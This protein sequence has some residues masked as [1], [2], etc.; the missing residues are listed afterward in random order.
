MRKPILL[1]LFSILLQGALMAQ[2]S[3]SGRITGKDG[4]PLIG[5]TVAVKGAAKGAATD[6]D[7]H[8]QLQ[9][10]SAESVLQFAYTGYQSKEI[11][12]GNQSN[13]D[14]L[15]EETASLINEVVVV[16]Y[17]AQKRSN[18]SGAVSTITAEE[19]S[20]LPILRTEQALQ[21][22]T[23]GVQVTQN[24]GS[25]GS[26]LTVRV[27]G[28]GTINNSDPLYI[29]DG[30]PV[31]GLDFLNPNDIESINVLK[32]AA[33]SAIYGARGAN[34]VVLITTRNG[35]KNQEGKIRYEAYFGMQSTWKKTNLLSAEEYAIL[36]NEAHIAAGVKPLPEFSNPAALGKGTNWLDAIFATAPM[37]SHQ[38]SLTGGSDKSTYSISGNYFNQ[39]GIVG[40][41]KAAFQRYT[42]RLNGTHEVK[43]WLNIGTNVGLT[44]LTRNGLPENNEFTTPLVRALNMDPVTP[45]RKADGTYAYSRYSDT[46]ITNPVNAIEQTHDR[47]R[48]NRLVG[49][50]YGELKLAPGLTYRSTYSVDA[51]FATQDIFY[52][53]FDLSNNTTLS[54]APAGEKRLINSVVKNNNTWRNW[55]WEN[56]LSWQ[57]TFAEAHVFNFTAGTT[58]LYNYHEYSGG[59]NT[60]LPSNNPKDAYI[61]NT[62]DPIASQSAYGGADE[63]ALNSYFG[64]VNYAYDDRYI[65]SGAFRMDGSSRFGANN[66]FGYFPSVSAGWILSHEAFWNPDLIN[67]FKLRASWGQN[68]NDKIG[69][70]SFTTIVNSGQNYTFGPTQTITNGSVSLRA[71]NPDLKWETITQTDFGVDLELFKGR[72]NFTGDYYIK[73]TSD[74]LY[75]APVP[76]TAGTEP[77]VRNVASVRNKGLELALNYRNRDHD[78]KYSVGGNISFVKNEVTSLG[79]GGEPVFAGRVQSANA[80]VSKTTIGQPIGAFFGYVTDG[81]FQTRD[82]VNKGA[83]QNEATAPGDI[84]F[85]D[86]NGDKVINEKDQTWIGN[87]APK[88]TYGANIDFEYKG[89]DLGIFLQGSYGN[90]IYNAT[91]RYDFTY[92]NR[93]VSVLN[94]W[95]GPGT[96]ES[97]PRVN[98][99][100]PNQNARV[101][102]RFVED[103]SYIRVKNVQLGYNLPASILKKVKCDKFRLYVSSQNLFTFTKYKGMD[104]EIG[105]YNGALEAGIDRGFY[106]QARVWLGGINVTF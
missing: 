54:D 70:Y 11:V 48:S 59:A 75:A 39:E 94:R 51:T 42:V 18:I 12:V 77:P 80:N 44:A 43:K 58:A 21:G 79:E 101:S 105:A 72:L 33:S 86:L 64:R 30:I 91:V 1:L 23:A 57:K 52:P 96:S 83:F 74:M 47:W 85:K 71:A 41:S 66:R 22:R 98:L 97:E 45:I 104:P 5:V 103:G 69:N 32:D 2:M 13:I 88:F 78:F 37:T 24:S 40:G 28:T 34:G 3:V 95:T 49:S 100:D 26:A 102:N 53:R 27:R 4:E 61:S 84:R 6:Y 82:E 17:G 7:G 87:P 68:G 10:L 76:L 90:D 14:V 60:N 67:F 38:L 20:E 81:I 50:V 8:Y 31:D 93:P 92:V 9:G 36:S 56:V 99:S 89:F 29:V 15:L 16:G 46:D 35:K 19:I 65:F 55:Q 63:S 25:P 62:I 73:N 106:P